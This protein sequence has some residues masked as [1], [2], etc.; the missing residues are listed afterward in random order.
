FSGSTVIGTVETPGL[1]AQCWEIAE[2]RDGT[3]A[4]IGFGES[5]GD[6][7]CHRKQSTCRFGRSG[8]RRRLPWRIVPRQ[9]Q[10]AAAIGD[11]L[12]R[13]AE[14]ARTGDEVEKVA[15]LAGGAVGL[16]CS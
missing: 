9:A 3:A 16:M 4:E 7:P 10:K 14:A 1:E 5:A 13:S 6:R 2:I 15:V 12:V 11:E 8:R